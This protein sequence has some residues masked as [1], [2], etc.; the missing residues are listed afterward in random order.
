MQSE[1]S[2]MRLPR[3]QNRSC[4]LGSDKHPHPLIGMDISFSRQCYKSLPSFLLAFRC[5]PFLSSFLSKMAEFEV[6]PPPPHTHTH[7]GAGQHQ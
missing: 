5:P 3:G 1:D 2:G 7:C 4:R 6:R